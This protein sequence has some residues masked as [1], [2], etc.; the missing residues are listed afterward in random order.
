MTPNMY[1]L[2]ELL[3][4]PIKGTD[5]QCCKLLL[6]CLKLLQTDHVF[7]SDPQKGKLYFFPA[8]LFCNLLQYQKN[9]LI[10]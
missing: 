9:E 5:T 3:P 2:I 8:G 10:I 7:V 6:L 1:A 4:I